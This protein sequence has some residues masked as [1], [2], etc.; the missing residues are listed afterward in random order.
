MELK[1]VRQL[2]DDALK[3]MNIT[4]SKIEQIISI[5]PRLSE[6]LSGYREMEVKVINHQFLLCG[7]EG[8]PG[9]VDDIKNLKDKSKKNFSLVVKIASLIGVILGILATGKAFFF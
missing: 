4:L 9:A 6:R 7:V 8:K 5:L 2:I 1:E 3:P